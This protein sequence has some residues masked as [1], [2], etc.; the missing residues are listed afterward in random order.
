MSR[1]VW[2]EINRGGVQAAVAASDDPLLEE[3]HADEGGLNAGEV[4]EKMKTVGD[5]PR[6]FPLIPG[7]IVEL[8]TFVAVPRE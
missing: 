1:G 3:A 2:I 5:Q 4:D 7:P 8:R 6:R